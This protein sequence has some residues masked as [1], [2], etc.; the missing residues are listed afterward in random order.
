M[1]KI[2]FSLLSLL[3]CWVANGNAQQIIGVTEDWPPYNYAD[4]G[5]VKGLATEI[6]QATL[7]QADS[8]ATIHVY[9]W[10]RAYN[11]ALKQEN[12]LIYSIR[13][14]PEREALFKWIGP[15]FYQNIYLV[16]LK[17]RT[18]IVLTSL[19]D[20]KR[21]RLGVMNQDSSHHFLL[22]QGFE[23]GVNLDT[24]SSET[25]NVKKLFAGR[26][27][28]L[29][30]NN[31]SLA[32]RMQELELPL[33]QVAKALPLYDKDQEFFM[34]FSK[35]TSDEL[36]NRVRKAFAQLQAAGIIDAILAKHLNRGQQNC[37]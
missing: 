36:V 5:I 24:A 18:D 2:I 4:N 1:Q 27:D 32:I 26:I 3:I 13:R 29:V 17:D 12:V 35:Q 22:R 16:R 31:I 8:E 25:L 11:M 10:A 34:A 7:A 37:P 6:V 15:I 9:P 30:Q 33:S 19:E 14:S 20:A 28:L 21:Y 23:E